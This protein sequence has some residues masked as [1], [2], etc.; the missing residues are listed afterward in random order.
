M[1]LLPDIKLH[2]LLIGAMLNC[3]VAAQAESAPQLATVAAN[4]A[5]GDGQVVVASHHPPTR[6]TSPQDAGRSSLSIA[7]SPHDLLG[8]VLSAER[9]GSLRGGT[10]IT[11]TEATLSAAVTGNVATSVLT[12]SNTIDAGSFA[13]MTGIPVVIQNTGANVLIQ[14]AT[15]INLQ[16]K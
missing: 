9:L 15:V 8:P 13:N 12:G 3:T 4:S 7:K 6:A 14:N 10:D 1:F 2:T 11:T 16:M 5:T